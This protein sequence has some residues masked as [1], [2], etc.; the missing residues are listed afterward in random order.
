MFVVLKLKVIM[1]A[2]S[3]SILN[4][5]IAMNPILYKKSDYQENVRLVKAKTVAVRKKIA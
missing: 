4:P 2:T 5:D 1:L 3:K